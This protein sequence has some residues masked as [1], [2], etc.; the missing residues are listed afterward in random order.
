MKDTTYAAFEG[1][2]VHIVAIHLAYCHSSIVV[3]VH[4]DERESSVC[5]ESRLHDVT[6][7]LEKGYDVGGGGI[8][9]E[10]ADVAR[11]L[12][13]GG[14]VYDDLVTGKS[15]GGKLVVAERSR[16]RHAHGLHRIL[17]RDGRLAFLISP[18]APDSSRT[19]PLAVHGAQ[20][21]LGI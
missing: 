11:S 17:L 1:A 7:I 12:P 13:S 21:L 8:G 20:S 16:R 5:L 4:F 6:K 9:R 19:E 10:I 15:V 18:V 2:T 3:R 14:L